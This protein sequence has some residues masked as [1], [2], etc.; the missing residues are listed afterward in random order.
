MV[1]KRIPNS[2]QIPAPVLRAFVWLRE[3]VDTAIAAGGGG[4]GVTDHGL[5]TG[6]GD[7][8]HAQYH[9][10]TRGDVRYT[11]R[12]NNLSDVASTATSRTNLGLG[13]AAVLNVGTT[14][15]TVAAGN[16][17][18]L[19]DARTPTA[20]AASHTNG[21]SDPITVATGN[22]AANA[23]DNT[24]LATVATATFKGRVTAATGNV[25]DLTATQATSLL[26]TFTS[27]LKGLVPASGGGTTNFLR[28]DGTWAAAGGGSS[29][30]S[31]TKGTT[32]V[33]NNSN[34]VLVN[35]TG[36]SFSLSAN[37]MYHFKFVGS[38]QSAATTTGIGFSFTG[39]A[40][41]YA[42]WFAEI[43][44]G[45]NGTDQ[46]FTYS[47]ANSLASIASSASVVAANTD[48]IWKIEGYVQPSAAGTLQLQFRS[49]VNASTVT[50]KA[51]SAGVLTDC[52]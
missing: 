28:A 34:T 48:Y 21:G 37:R 22:I 14:A 13:G 41:T 46:M 5:L 27:A 42:F 1:A 44:Q 15:G 3:Y 39:P 50:L 17:S 32:Q 20:H 9:N 38:F 7:D 52:G 25:E 10:D 36:L 30:V 29:P 18:R 6:L 23:V 47:A 40:V 33:T 2:Q 43:Q 31:V 12:A 35:A 51:G 16:D 49:E 24:K 8:D 45:A 26:D 11:Q 4:G 19:S